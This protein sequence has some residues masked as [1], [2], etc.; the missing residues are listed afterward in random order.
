MALLLYNITKGDITMKKE[1]L[2]IFNINPDKIEDYEIKEISKNN[3]YLYIKYKKILNQC[4]V[5]FNLTNYVC[6]YRNRIIKLPKMINSSFK[7]IYKQRRYI[8]NLCGKKFIEKNEIVEKWSHISISTKNNILKSLHQT[9]TYTQIAKDND[10]SA[11]TVS[12]IMDKNF[13]IKTKIKLPSKISIDEFKFSK[14]APKYSLMIFDLENNKIFD[15]IRDRRTDSL[16]RYFA[17][18]NESDRSNVE[19]VCMDLWRPYKTIVK[20]FFPNAEI[21]ADKFHYAR[22]INWALRDVRIKTYNE[23]DNKTIKRALRDSWK[24]I[25]TPLYKLIGNCFNVFKR[26]FTSKYEFLL[27]VMSKNENLKNTIILYN[28]FFYNFQKK[29]NLEEATNFVDNYIKKLEHFNIPEFKD[30]IS[31]F[32]NW[33]KEIINSLVIRDSNNKFY[34]NGKIEGV[35]NFIK[36]YNKIGYGYTNSLRFA[37]RI[38]MIFNFKKQFA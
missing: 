29:Y 31:S 38:I 20:K 25:Q 8:C 23:S 6:D 4:P 5:C 26:K 11:T 34:S 24:I 16:E 9:L 30:V 18:F 21:I 19:I 14:K 28:D 1:V 2:K 22:H 36:T 7:I 17:R 12:N 13:D 15:I 27:D 35:N 33:R 32:K 37:E 3:F 10:V